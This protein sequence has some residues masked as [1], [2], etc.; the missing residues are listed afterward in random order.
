[1][2]AAKCVS[3]AAQNA[4][5]V[6]LPLNLQVVSVERLA[7]EDFANTASSTTVIDGQLGVL[8]PR[9]PPRIVAATLAASAVSESESKTT[10]S[11]L[12]MRYRSFAASACACFNSGTSVSACFHRVRKSS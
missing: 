10:A 12:V 8:E 11:S 9:Q 1:V 3:C 7:R 6:V 2:T 5:L 4:A